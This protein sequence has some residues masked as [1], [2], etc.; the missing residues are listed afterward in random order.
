MGRGSR[1][2]QERLTL[3]SGGGGKLVVGVGVRESAQWPRGVAM[4]VGGGG[5]GGEVEVGVGWW[6]R[7]G[8]VRERK[9]L[10]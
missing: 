5:V 4:L 6:E 9:G 8:A 1:A 10:A 7:E 2:K 3:H